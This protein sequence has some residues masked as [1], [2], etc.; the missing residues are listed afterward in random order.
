VFHFNYLAQ[1]LLMRRAMIRG[2]DHRMRDPAELRDTTKE[3]GGCGA[4]LGW[5]LLLAAVLLAL[6]YVYAVT[7]TGV[8]W[9]DDEGTLMLT[10]RDLADG[11]VLYNSV[12]ALYGPFYY[13][14]AGI[15]FF[16]LKVP[17]THDAIRMMSVVFW[18]AC[19]AALAV[20]VYRMTLSVVSAGFSFIAVLFLLAIFPQTSL[21]PQEICLLLLILLLHLIHGLELRPGIGKLVAIGAIVAALSLTK[22]NVGIF[23]GASVTLVA[24]RMTEPRSWPRMGY[25]AVAISSLFLPVALMAQLMRFPW[26]VTYCVFSTTILASTLLVWSRS[27]V[28]VTLTLGHWVS[29]VGA[30]FVSASLWIGIVV[31][32]GTTPHAVLT[33]VV[34]QN[35]QFIQNWYVAMKIDP[36]S[37]AVTIVSALAAVAYVIADARPSSRALARLGLLWFKLLVGGVGITFVSYVAFAWVPIKGVP[38]LMFQYLLPF[39]WIMAVPPFADR[40][41]LPATRGGMALLAAFMV[42][43]AFPIGGTQFIIACVLPVAMLS[44]L[45][46]DAIVGLQFRLPIGSS[47]APYWRSGGIALA[48]IGLAGMIISQSRHAAKEHAAAVPLDLPGAHLIRVRPEAA[49]GHRWVVD[50][51]A[52]CNTFYS[53]LPGL[54]SFYFWTGK[55]TPTAINS[56]NTLGLLSWTQQDRVIADLSKHSDLCILQAPELAKLFDRGQIATNPPLMRYVEKNFVVAAEHAPYRLLKRKANQD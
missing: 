51:L 1:I 33:A 20:L 40:A 3:T 44:V 32:G 17:L 16:D 39:C 18:L 15:L 45:L 2:H 52:R 29:A 36:L 12:Y 24:L 19:T 5:I 38:R 8:H 27:S 10:F 41:V 21:H 37:I 31:F 43:Y 25:M 9:H 30:A 26:V 34:L 14:V 35:V 28:A 23:A 49:R 53:M 7:F 50:Q 55:S 22:L 56:N 47:Y 11:G 42:L 4:L 46:H 54:M 13:I 6:P 48:T